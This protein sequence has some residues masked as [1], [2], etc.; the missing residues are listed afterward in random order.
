M[1]SLIFFQNVFLG[2][3]LSMSSRTLLECSICEISFDEGD[4]V[5]ITKCNHKFH[6][7]CA[8]DRL[9]TR[10]R[11]DCHRCARASV[12]GEALNQYRNA[13]S[14]DRNS[15]SILSNEDENVS[16]SNY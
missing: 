7:K 8:Q 1:I 4:E 5:V 9:L 11:S 6:R 2:L 10:K 14:T 3:D 12:L 16:S 13:S 15:D